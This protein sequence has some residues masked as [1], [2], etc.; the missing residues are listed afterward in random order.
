[1]D[2]DVKPR[3]TIRDFPLD[4]HFN[5]KCYFC[6]S[7]HIIIRSS[8]WREVPDLGSPLEE[9]IARVKSATIHCQDCGAQFTPEHPLFP[10][11]YEYSRA[12]VEYALISFHY[13]NI[14]GE[15]IRSNLQTLHRVS[16]PVATIY[17]WL[18][19]LSPTFLKARLEAHTAEDLS[20]IKTITVDG[21]YVNTGS[22]IIGKKKDVES[23]SVT[24]LADGRYLLMWWE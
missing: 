6:G 23:L 17:S 9:I 19:D 7:S 3:K 2:F 14:S 12:I 24:K 8:Y 22:A 1:M 10:P 20:K 11:K 15:Q 18:K 21:T 4:S 5:G 13:N 16:V